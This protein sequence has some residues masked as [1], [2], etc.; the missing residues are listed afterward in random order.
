MLFGSIGGHRLPLGAGGATT[1]GPKPGSY[2]ATNAAGAVVAQSD[3]PKLLEGACTSDSRLIW[4]LGKWQVISDDTEA[5]SCTTQINYSAQDIITQGDPIYVGPFLWGAVNGAVDAEAAF[6][7]AT[8]RAGTILPAPAPLPALDGSQITAID[9]PVQMPQGWGDWFAGAFTTALKAG[10]PTVDSDGASVWPVFYDPTRAFFSNH[11]P[12]YCCADKSW[13]CAPPPATLADGTP[14]TTGITECNCQSDPGCYEG[15]Q[16]TTTKVTYV[17]AGKDVNG[18]PCEIVTYEDNPYTWKWFFVSDWLESLK[19][20]LSQQPGI[21]NFTKVLQPG[22]TQADLVN[23]LFTYSSTPNWNWAPMS[24]FRHPVTG[25]MWGVWVVFVQDSSEVVLGAWNPIGDKPNGYTMQI[26][27]GLIPSEPWYDYIVDA[28][29][30]IP[31]VLGQLASFVVG[32]LLDIICSN[33]AGIAA[34]ASSPATMKSGASAAAGAA[35]TAATKLC[36]Q[37]PVPGVNC[38]DPANAANP[39]C[40]PP[41][42]TPWYEQWYVIAGVLFLIGFSVI[43]SGKKEHEGS[44]P[45]PS[46]A[47]PSSEG[48]NT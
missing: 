5:K 4:T 38:L 47:L 25:D 40:L 22:Q 29:E 32:G 46:P 13:V 3:A 23:R 34:A 43:V 42:I 1:L 35:L 45:S 39:L 41:V 31:G 6:L 18:F 12:T 9:D 37:P 33:P 36:P 19:V 7:Q 8:V 17:G 30:W 16:S 11:L 28:I 27:I 24:K 20:G 26:A 21:I 14:N 44:T 10:L 15:Y 48:S 2:V